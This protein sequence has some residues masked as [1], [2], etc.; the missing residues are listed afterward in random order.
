M[1]CHE[2]L[3]NKAM[4][5]SNWVLDHI[6]Q[7]VNLSLTQL[8]RGGDSPTDTDFSTNPSYVLTIL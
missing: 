7:L 6:K 4:V 8:N 3:A 1:P 2:I 5:P